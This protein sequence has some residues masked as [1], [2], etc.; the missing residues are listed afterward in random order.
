MN[1]TRAALVASVS[2]VALWTA[3]AVAIASAGGL[4]KSPLEGPLFMLGLLSCVAGG[5]LVGAAA[6]AHRSIGWRIGG[7]VLSLVAVAAAGTVAQA[8]VD[9]VQPSHPGWVYGEI[10]LWAS[11]LV[12]VV[13]AVSLGAREDTRDRDRRPRARAG[14]G[15]LS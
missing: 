1:L 7:A 3:K 15:S 13:A 14:A 12:L 4:G 9:A 10:N 11:M 5:V 6:F 2:T 8:V